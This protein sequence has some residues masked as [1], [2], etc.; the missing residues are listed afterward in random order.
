M[1]TEE[2]M[3]KTETS[4]NL[5]KIQREKLK[6]QMEDLQELTDTKGT[7][8]DLLPMR[9]PTD[10]GAT[11][12]MNRVQSSPLL[13]VP[14]LQSI[15]K[16]TAEAY[17]FLEEKGR[18]QFKMPFKM[19]KQ[20]EQKYEFEKE[21]FFKEKL[22]SAMTKKIQQEM[23]REKHELHRISNALDS[24]TSNLNDKTSSSTA[25]FTLKKSA[26]M[27]RTFSDFPKVKV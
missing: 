15:S 5:I 19:Q 13:L 22:A 18:N 21:T 27:S 12:S 9:E 14:G 7:N 6:K 8:F 23:N 10:E 1:L 20:A 25:A 26:S 2:N 16:T 11:Q 24:L 4:P 3:L 17:K